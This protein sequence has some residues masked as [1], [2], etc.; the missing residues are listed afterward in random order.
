MFD[1]NKLNL[2]ILEISFLGGLKYILIK[3]QYSYDL[4]IV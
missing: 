2:Y 4:N 3:I 1:N